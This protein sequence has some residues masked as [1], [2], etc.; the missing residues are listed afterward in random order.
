MEIMTDIDILL[1]KYFSG[2]ASDK[3]LTLL[4]NWLAESEENQ[5]YFDELTAIYEKSAQATPPRKTDTANAWSMFEQ[6]M[7]SPKPTIKVKRS[8]KK[9]RLYRQIAASIIV[10]V[11]VSAFLFYRS[12]QQEKLIRIAS[13][14]DAVEH[15]M[16]DS[17][18]VRL[19]Q[20]SS[21]TYKQ[22]YENDNETIA[23]EGK[24]SFDVSGKSS[25]KL[26]IS[27]GETFIK[28]IGT[29]FAVDGYAQNPHISVSVKSGI[30]LFYT[31]ENSG[32][33]L[34]QGETGY[35][36]KSSKQFSKQVAGKIVENSQIVFNATPLAKVIERLSLQLNANIVLASDSLS[37]RQITVSFSSKDDI[38]HILQVIAETLELELKQQNSTYA[39][40][41]R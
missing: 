14:E 37:S 23:L 32:L 5:A 13:S 29:E 18:V 12:S 33:S 10:L 34:Y 21:I 38:G 11:G 4:D 17:S 39:L 20:N 27:I 24:A 31:E 7:N 28:D 22:D 30:V 36:D 1:A 9:I 8:T 3:E 15:V 16:P 6:H 40:H 2:E 26:V 19:A 35:F 25:G 41:S